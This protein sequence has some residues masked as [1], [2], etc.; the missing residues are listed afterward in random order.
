MVFKKMLAAL[1]VGGPS[2]DTVLDTP[3]ARPGGFLDGHVHIQG[4]DADARIEHVVL[5]LATGA[6]DLHRESVADHFTVRA[7][8]TESIPFR[9]AVPWETPI[10]SVYDRPL[11]GMVMGV[12]TELE[13]AGARDKG[14]LDPVSITPLPAQQA[15]LDAFAEL[16]FRFKHAEVE[17]GHLQGVP[18]RL[19]IHQE[20]EFWPPDRYAG[21]VN[22]VELTFV[23]DPDGLEV[24]LALDRRGGHDAYS[25]FGI[26]H[27][28]AGA[29]NWT[30]MVDGWLREATDRHFSA[31]AYGHGHG[32]GS[33]ARRGMGMGTVVAAGAAGIVGGLVAGEVIDEVFDDGG[34]FGDF[35]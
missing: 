30:A 19:P 20:I 31:P 5:A 33:H 10:T 7:G 26:T 13:I 25:R 1:G 14:D 22:E 35:E 11:R 16:G 29:T 12:R 15:I 18:Q 34:D 4:G 6:L 3:T 17:H 21:R 8:T 24:L 27:A 9:L 32:H 2:V 28:A 23:A